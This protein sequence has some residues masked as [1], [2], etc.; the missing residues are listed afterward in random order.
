MM[1]VEESINTWPQL[2][3]S[4][5]LGGAVGADVSRRILLGQFHDSGR[6]YIDLDELIADKKAGTDAKV[7]EK[8]APLSLSQMEAIIK[9][10]P[11][12]GENQPISG[13]AVDEMVTAACLAPSGGNVQPW[14]WVYNNG[15]LFLFHDIH[16]S[17]SLLDY[18]NYGSYVG[19]GAA[20]ENLDLKARSM[21]YSIKVEYF[22]IKDNDN[23]V[24]AIALS[25][26]VNGQEADGLASYI[27]VRLTNR[28][29][30]SYDQLSE[31]DT[32]KF[33]AEVAKIQGA[34]INFITDRDVMRQLGEIVS[35]AD[36][37]RM[38]NEQ[39]HYD[40][41]FTE[42]RWNAK[43]AEETSDGID[44][45]TVGATPS[46]A[47]GFSI[48]KDY[49][50]I[51]L[52]KD[53]NKGTAFKKL[54]NKIVN[55]SS[56]MAL[57]TMPAGTRADYL[58]GGRAVERAW[59]VATK[60]GYAFQP[61]SVPLFLFKRLT[62]GKGVGFTVQDMENLTRLKEDYN[63]ILPGYDTK[64]HIFLFRLGRAEEPKVKS[65]RRNLKEVLFYI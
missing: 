7:Y 60:L 20:I 65:L 3:S 46:E 30:G 26:G 35:G 12:A 23:L 34:D 47:A 55:V 53:W 58:L 11:A 56:A 9:N 16:F 39:G 48:A 31:G 8:P 38:M 57:I 22:P 44:I 5:I 41:F 18:N 51:K 40:T 43:D 14:K 59:L 24:A 36:M 13:N 25:Q 21:G 28:N 45:A 4:V 19:L 32:E 29:T 17:Y 62:E 52:L 2:A 63:R 15:R 49:E 42:M 10:Y 1:E 54:T 64:G 50:A 27:S 33:K 37:V 61:L 6:Y